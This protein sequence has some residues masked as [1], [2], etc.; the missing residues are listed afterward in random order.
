M[1]AYHDKFTAVFHQQR[2]HAV[3]RHSNDDRKI[4][5]KLQS[6]QVSLLDVKI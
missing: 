4:A 2:I 5:I 6:T 1:T 3:G